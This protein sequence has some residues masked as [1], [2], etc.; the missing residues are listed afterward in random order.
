MNL[1]YNLS[2]NVVSSTFRCDG[3]DYCCLDSF[4]LFVRETSLINVCISVA[5]L[6]VKAVRRWFRFGRQLLILLSMVIALFLNQTNFSN[7]FRLFLLIST[8]LL[9][10]MMEEI[11]RFSTIL[12]MIHLGRNQS[13]RI[14]D[15]RRAM[16]STVQDFRFFD[17]SKW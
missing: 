6:V 8:Y 1:R 13:L 10:I 11:A 12:P 16:T 7:S 2:L 17:E 14:Y 15:Q 3:T 5:T 9:Q 4:F